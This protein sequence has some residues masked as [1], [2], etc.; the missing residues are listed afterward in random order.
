MTKT[1]VGRGEDFSIHPMI[2]VESGSTRIL[3]VKAGPLFYAIGDTCTHMGCSLSGG[4]LEGENVRCRC[5]GSVFNA[6]T[7]EVIHGPATKPE[8]SFP[9]T[10]ENGDV[11]VDG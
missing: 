6:R 5:H 4:T 11:F 9:V 7:G 8:H 3:V 1:K 2:T 10:V